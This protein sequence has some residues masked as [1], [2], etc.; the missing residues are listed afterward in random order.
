M[1]A[2]VPPGSSVEPADAI[3]RELS[4]GLVVAGGVLFTALGAL[5]ALV[6]VLLVPLRIGGVVA[7]VAAVLAVLANV[8]L[9]RLAAETADRLILPVLPVA[10]WVLCV[11]VLSQSRPEGDVLLPGGHTG[12]TYV[13]YATLLLG[14]ATGVA[15]VSLLGTRR[16]RAGP[17]TVR[18]GLSTTAVPRAGQ[19]SRR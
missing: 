16:S 15:T 9:P 19:S 7:P 11:L 1:A 5:A 3:D 12:V 17:G 14:L 2:A 4:P 10:A 18:P 13:A 8:A 6:T